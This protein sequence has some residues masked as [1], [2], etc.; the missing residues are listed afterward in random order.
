MLVMRYKCKRIREGKSTLDF[1][2][3]GF[4]VLSSILEIYEIQK[5]AMSKEQFIQE[6][7]YCL[8]LLPFRYVAFVEHLTD[9]LTE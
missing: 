7:K 4:Q 8:A 9:P 2:H 6:V 3:L 1:S 5:N